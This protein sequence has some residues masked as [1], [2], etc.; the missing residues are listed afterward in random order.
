MIR[1]IIKYED[2]SF[3]LTGKGNV[4]MTCE[5]IADLLGVLAVS[6]GKKAKRIAGR[7][8]ENV[9]S[10]PSGNGFSVGVYSLE[11]VIALAHKFD[12]ANAKLFRKWVADEVAYARRKAKPCIIVNL[13]TEITE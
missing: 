9:K 6:V 12:T 4:W 2:G 7:Y 11:T 5:E 8:S 1:D 3:T 13:K 10:L